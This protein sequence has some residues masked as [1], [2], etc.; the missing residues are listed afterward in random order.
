MRE[1]VREVENLG[2]AGMKPNDFTARFSWNEILYKRV[3]FGHKQD[4]RSIFIR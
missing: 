1:N 4:C 3:K 2:M